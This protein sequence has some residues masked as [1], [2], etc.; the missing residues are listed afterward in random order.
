MKTT[1]DGRRATQGEIDP[2][3]YEFTTGPEE[4]ITITGGSVEIK[5]PG[6]SEFRRCATG[7]MIVV[8]PASNFTIRATE[9]ASYDCI[10]IDSAPAGVPDEFDDDGDDIDDC[11]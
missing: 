8:P 2:G 1:I 6:E 3:E 7:D 4:R 11:R 10:Y 9:L 5:L